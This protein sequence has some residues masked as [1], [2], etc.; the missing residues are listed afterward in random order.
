M[1]GSPKW[2]LSLRFPHQNLVHPFRLPR[3]HLRY[4]RV[5]TLTRISV[6]H[7]LLCKPE[8]IIGEL[9]NFEFPDSSLCFTLYPEPVAYYAVAQLV[10]ALCYKS[11]GSGFDS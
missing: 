2:T 1:P 11:E 6:D 5:S 4:Y 3:T 9:R 8:D 10:E 7:C